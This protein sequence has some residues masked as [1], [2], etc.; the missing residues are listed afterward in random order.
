MLLAP[1]LTERSLS[2]LYSPRGLGKSWLGL[3]IGLAV[4][5]GGSVLRWNAAE[6][7]YPTNNEGIARPEHIE[8]PPPFGPISKLGAHAG[9]PVV[10]H[11][12]I[13]VKARRLGVRPLVGQSLLGGADPGVQDGSARRGLFLVRKGPVL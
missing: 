9:H 2:M 3:S 5:S 12:L 11:Y 1:I 13:Q 10:R 8:Q 4:A 7:V 6:A